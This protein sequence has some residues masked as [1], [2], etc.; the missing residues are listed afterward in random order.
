M[1]DIRVAAVQMESR[2]LDVEAN[3]ARLEHFARQAAAEGAKLVSLPECCITSYMPLAGLSRQQLA[4]IAEPVPDGPACR[5]L[6]RLAR[7]CG[8][9]IAAGLIEA[10]DDGRLYKAYVVALPDGQV[11]RHR[12]FHPF[13]HPAL[14]PGEE[15]TVFDYLG[16]R[17]GVL[18][19][20]DNNQPENGRVLATRG[21]QVVLAPHQTG[22]FPLRYAGMG[23]IDRR[24]WDNRHAD[25]TAIRA[26][27]IGP[28]GRQWLMR[29]LPSRAY[30]NGCY[31]VYSNGIGPDGSEIRTGGAMILDPH[32]R[33]MAETLAAA[34]DMVVAT[35]TGDVLEH[36]LGHSHMQTRRPDLYAA[37][38]APASAAMSTK[39][40]RDAAIAD[41]EAG[42][43]IDR[44]GAEGAEDRE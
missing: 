19:C 5:R 6:V 27:L 16:W 15:F 8:L 18:I 28:K 10:G 26:E 17:W 42:D 4:D 37:L 33:V 24:L 7:E 31:L 29:W 23:L 43:G 9:A 13:V 20:Y 44:R 40:S 39:A 25:P 22:G 41:G 21:V 30:D 35:L 36:N 12:K 3:L 32:G 34:D 2:A 1:Q 14:T 38:T 11:H